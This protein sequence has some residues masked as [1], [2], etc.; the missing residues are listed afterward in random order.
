MYS[1]HL[2]HV[3]GRAS[4]ATPQGVVC[5]ALSRHMAGG[6]Y[7]R[8][9]LYGGLSRTQLVPFPPPYSMVLLRP[10]NYFKTTR[11]QTYSDVWSSQ[12]CRIGLYSKH[13]LMWWS[14]SAGQP[15]IIVHNIVCISFM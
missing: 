5:A 14:V 11:H 13:N 12:T 10:S 8:E 2:V 4:V 9:P 1:L 15:H 7:A 6:S 3:G